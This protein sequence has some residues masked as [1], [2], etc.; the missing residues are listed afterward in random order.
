MLFPPHLHHPRQPQ[1]TQNWV[2]FMPLSKN[3]MYAEWCCLNPQ[4][5]TLNPESWRIG[6]ASWSSIFVILYFTSWYFC[7]SIVSFS[8]ENF[9]VL[10]G[11]GVLLFLNAF[12]LCHSPCNLCPTPRKLSVWAL[13]LEAVG[14]PNP[15]FWPKSTSTIAKVFFVLNFSPVDLSVGLQKGIRETIRCFVIEFRY[16]CMRECGV[17]L[18]CCV[19]WH[20]WIK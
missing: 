4:T 8:Q 11:I 12:V 2:Y 5:L 20:E 15:S 14:S 18:L 16:D 19:D 6:S 13:S 9:E 10:R 7:S 17:S 3:T 1:A